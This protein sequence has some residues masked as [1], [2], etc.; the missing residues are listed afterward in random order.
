MYCSI[1]EAW[2]T[3][4]YDN[5]T[6]SRANGVENFI[7]N[8]Q[9]NNS[10]LNKNDQRPQFGG[11]S[12]QLTEQMPNQY[13]QLNN[14]QQ[15]NTQLTNSYNAVNNMNYL[16][17][18]YNNLEKENNQLKFG[19]KLKNKNLIQNEH[20]N[21]NKDNSIEHNHNLESYG[22]DDF[23]LHLQNCEKCQ[24]AMYNKFKPSKMEELLTLNPNI[25]ETV[26]IF[27]VGLVVLLV[28]NL[29]YK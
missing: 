9:K 25:K 3:Y 1:E 10:I 11:F 24:I 21:Y 7:N 23:M 5:N 13:D 6:I 12:N 19:N 20:N 22:C 28:L 2:P 26:V 17:E 14:Y 16:L 29:F 15:H 8:E 4:N 18:K 27:L